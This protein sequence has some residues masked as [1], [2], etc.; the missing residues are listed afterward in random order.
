LLTLYYTGHIHVP[1][2]PGHRFPM[3]KYRLVREML[4]G[5]GF[6][7][8]PAPPAS[9]QAIERAHD[10]R[11]VGQVL[12]G[13]LPAPALRRIGFPWSPGLVERTLASVGAT[14]AAARDALRNGCG[15][16]LAGGTHHA[17][18]GEGS[19]FCV[20]NDLAVAILA[21]RAEHG[22]ARAAVIDLDVH[23]GDGTAQIFEHDPGVL[24][25]SMHGRNN[26]PF[27][28]QRSRIDIELD[29]GAGDSLYLALLDAA[30]PRVFDFQPQAVFYQAGVDPLATDTL[31][32]LALTPEG[33][34]ERDRRVIAA[35]K[36]WGAPFVV[37]LGGGYSD[38]IELTAAA[39][40]HTFRQL[41]SVYGSSSERQASPGGRG[42]G[43]QPPLGSPR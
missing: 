20:F 12:E 41:H 15:G 16:T 39:H 1:L 4:A 9:R 42:P 6:R 23:Q 2:P 40:A 30:L 29:D 7:F 43:P 17:F 33:L 21:L 27:R 14:L 11:Y 26:F 31:G 3:H 25:F 37:T 32:R 36:S 34:A 38:P 13:S 35:A 10:T 8:E 22:I 24:T 19:G 5:R 28:K 18:R